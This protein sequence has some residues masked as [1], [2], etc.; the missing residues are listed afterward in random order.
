MLRVKKK[1]KISSEITITI[2]SIVPVIM[3]N[4]FFIKNET[5]ARRGLVRGTVRI[6]SK[7]HQQG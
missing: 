1:K 6:K 5:R 2:R 4:R 3:I 7:A